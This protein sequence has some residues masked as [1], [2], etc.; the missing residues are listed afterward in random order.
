MASR[1]VL[2]GLGGLLTLAACLSFSAAARAV[3]FGFGPV[4]LGLPSFGLEPAPLS[5]AEA[6]ETVGVPCSIGAPPWSPPVTAKILPW[7]SVWL[8]HFS[9]GRPDPVFY[10][11]IDWRDEKVCFASKARCQAWIKDLRRAYHRPEGY[12]TCLLLR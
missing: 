7:P 6:P 8:G 9:G 10:G 3:D 11:Q 4:E 12:W 2:H 5:P 1:R